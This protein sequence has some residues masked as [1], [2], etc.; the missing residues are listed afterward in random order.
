[1][2]FTNFLSPSISFAACARGLPG[3]AQALFAM[4]EQQSL[5]F[6]REYARRQRLRQ[7]SQ[8]TSQK[9]PPRCA[10][11]TFG[12]VRAVDP[13]AQ[14]LAN[15]DLVREKASSETTVCF[16]P[17]PGERFILPHNDHT[18]PSW[19]PGTY[20]DDV[21]TNGSLK[22]DAEDEQIALRDEDANLAKAGGPNK[23]TCKFEY[24]KHVKKALELLKEEVYTDEA[25]RDREGPPFESP[26]KSD[27]TKNGSS[28]Q[29]GILED[30]PLGD[31]AEENKRNVRFSSIKEICDEDG[32]VGQD[33]VMNNEG[34]SVLW[35]QRWIAQ[36]MQMTGEADEFTKAAVNSLKELIAVTWRMEWRLDAA[37]AS[38]RN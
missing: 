25:W 7:Y 14:S 9:D 8:R 12:G 21:T 37:D 6:A 4:N 38:R 30:S 19:Y 5:F 17:H 35:M 29:S 31:E 28:R 13:E 34:K 10:S 27:V 16:E 22:V 24:K 3:E 11:E 18:E 20:F 2:E 1:M 26:Y 32:K 36:R 33:T 15:Q 23:R